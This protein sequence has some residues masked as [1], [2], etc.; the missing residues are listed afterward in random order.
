VYDVVAGLYDVLAGLYD[1]VA[2]I[3]VVVMVGSTI[4]GIDVTVVVVLARPVAGGD[5]AE[6]VTD[7]TEIPVNVV[8]SSPLSMYLFPQHCQVL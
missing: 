1:V 7:N 6:G 8:I 3:A 5:T 2:G 4:C